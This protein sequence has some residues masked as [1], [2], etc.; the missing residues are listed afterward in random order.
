MGAASR[1]FS[2]VE[3]TNGSLTFTPDVTG[4]QTYT[5]AEPG[6]WVVTSG[7]DEIALPQIG[8]WIG[9]PGLGPANAIGQIE[10]ANQTLTPQTGVLTSNFTADNCLW[11]VT[12]VVNPQEPEIAF[13]VERTSLI[14]PDDE[15]IASYSADTPPLPAARHGQRG[16]VKD[17]LL[18]SYS[19]D[20]PKLPD[21][22]VD[23]G[24]PTA[25]E[26]ESTHTDV[27]AGYAVNAEGL[28]DSAGTELTGVTVTGDEG[29]RA[30]TVP[31]FGIFLAVTGDDAGSMEVVQPRFASFNWSLHLY[32]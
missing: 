7:A 17:L 2:I 25:A 8:L 19:A 24:Q 23:P 27:H 4:L 15:E 18:D 10:N 21:R 14:S 13:R 11:A 12:T 29:E 9:E 16:A 28:P 20:T 3:L 5:A 26:Y 22:L 1:K 31:N 32:N 6:N 30:K